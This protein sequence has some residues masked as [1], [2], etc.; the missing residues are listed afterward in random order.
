[1]KNWDH[2]IKIPVFSRL[3]GVYFQHQWFNLFKISASGLRCLL[4]QEAVNRAYRRPFHLIRAY[5]RPFHLI[6]DVLKGKTV[7]SAM[8]WHR[9]KLLYGEASNAW[10]LLNW[11]HRHKSDRLTFSTSALNCYTS[12][13]AYLP[14]VTMMF[15]WIIVVLTFVN[16]AL[17]RL[18]QDSEHDGIQH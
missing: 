14:I 5:R 13:P 4:L 18:T 9:F 2:V 7:Y 17:G 16:G 10:Q 6:W 15:T 1:M 12:P 11:D 3:L 8:I